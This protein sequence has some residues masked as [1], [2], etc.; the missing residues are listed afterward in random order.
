[1]SAD[2]DLIHEQVAH[3]ARGC[4]SLNHNPAPYVTA[5]D[6]ALARIEAE[7]AALVE[8][9]EEVASHP[10]IAESPYPDALCDWHCTATL[11]GRAKDALRGHANTEGDRGSLAG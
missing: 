3:L 6:A 5:I 8:A 2:T 9:L 7:R 11:V 10:V 1:M 4:K